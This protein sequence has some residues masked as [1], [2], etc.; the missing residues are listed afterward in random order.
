MVSHRAASLRSLLP[1]ASA[2]VGPAVVAAGLVVAGQ[3]CGPPPV[4]NSDIGVE[5]EPIEAGEGAGTFALKTINATLVQVPVLGDF[6]GGGINYRLVKRTFNEDSN[7][8]TQ[9]SRLC[10]GFNFE[11]AGVTTSLPESTYRA[12]APSVTETVTISDDGSYV[13]A[14]HIQLWG[15]R[16]LPDPYT[17]DLPSD[18]DDAQNEPHKSR[19]FDMDDDDNDGVTTFISGA[20]EGQVFIV[21][22][23][24]VEIEGVVLG[25]DRALGLATNTNEVVQLGNTNVLLD[26]QSEGSAEAHPDPKLS[27]FEEV[28]VADDA[29]CDLVMAAED[30]GILSRVRPF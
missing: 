21:Q 30:D 25:P 19:I 15:L 22:R 20:V 4:F 5:A 6:Q 1:T 11:V 28:R 17:T 7:T 27:W 18:K 14:G 9:E 24:T 16:D 3:G 29:D 10:G 8:Y 23:K 26:R 2:V 13:G 12:V